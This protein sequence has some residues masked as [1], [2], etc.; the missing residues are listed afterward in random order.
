MKPTV[1]LLQQVS[2]LLDHKVYLEYTHIFALA[3]AIKTIFFIANLQLR[4]HHRKKS[5]TGKF[6]IPVFFFQIFKQIH[7]KIYSIKKHRKCI[8]VRL[9]P[10]IHGEKKSFT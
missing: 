4:H 7:L 9:F 2:F 1:H 8:L 6:E 5:R 10:L 3:K